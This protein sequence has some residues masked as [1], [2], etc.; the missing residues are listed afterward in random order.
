[1]LDP[2]TEDNAEKIKALKEAILVLANYL[3]SVVWRT[4]SE[5]ERT[6]INI[7]AEIRKILEGDVK[8]KP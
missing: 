7:H 2:R 1:M 5:P 3:D 6:G 4:S 8:S